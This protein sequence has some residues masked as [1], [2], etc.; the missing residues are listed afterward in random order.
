M[1]IAGAM[2]LWTASAPVC[3]QDSLPDRLCIT[4]DRWEQIHQQGGIT[5]YAQK[6]PVSEVLAF[7]AT[8]VLHA[9]V[10]QVMEVLRRVDITGEWMPDISVKYTV[11][12]WSDFKAITY[13]INLMPWPFADRELLLMNR[14]RLDPVRKYLVV[15]VY[16]VESVGDEKIPVAKGNVR[17]HMY[18][19]ETMIR[20]GREGNTEVEMILFIDPKGFIP[21]WLVNIFQKS[22][23]Y[24]F[25]KA[26]EE[27]AATTDYPLRPSY[28][29]L[30]SDLKSILP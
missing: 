29:K 11:K 16:S 8:A 19:G 15:E 13:S 4:A 22:L 2:L 1:A 10:E 7:R 24:N 26:L 28:Q 3:A 18:C 5:V 25:L 23:P 12:E 27:K 14:L 9:P 21:A 20:P 30:L 6:V 17:A